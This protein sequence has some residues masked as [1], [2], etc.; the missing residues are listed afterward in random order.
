MVPRVW[1]PEGVCRG[2]A[3]AIHGVEG[4]GEGRRYLASVGLEG[5]GEEPDFH[6]PGLFGGLEVP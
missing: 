2:A 1:L 3:F 4:V 6:Q 5:K